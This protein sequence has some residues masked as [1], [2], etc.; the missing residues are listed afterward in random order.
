MDIFDM[1]TEHEERTRDNCIAAARNVKEEAKATGFCLFCN[2]PIAMERR[3]CSVDCRED[4]ELEKY[5]RI[6]QK[7]RF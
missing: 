2:E 4:W 5:S 1:A 6:R 3:F 7:G